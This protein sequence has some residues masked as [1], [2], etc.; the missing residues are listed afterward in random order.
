[1]SGRREI[2]FAKASNFP[3]PCRGL[4]G[5]LPSAG[6]GHLFRG[7][8]CPSLTIKQKARECFQPAGQVTV[9]NVSLHGVHALVGKRSLRFGKLFE[10]ARVT[11][12]IAL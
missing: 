3:H 9:A 8:I 2:G 4:P 11:E 5:A 1:M 6:R 7:S 10:I 12:P